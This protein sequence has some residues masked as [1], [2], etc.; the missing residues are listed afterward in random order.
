MGCDSAY[1]WDIFK[2]SLTVGQIA[3]SS[4][5]VKKAAAP[6]SQC[7]QRWVFITCGMRFVLEVLQGNSVTSEPGTDDQSIL[8]VAHRKQPVYEQPRW[9]VCNYR[10]A[11]GVRKVT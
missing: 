4:L 9:P 11:A 1:R 2:V 8:A 5:S 10:H 7:G 3:A 6:S